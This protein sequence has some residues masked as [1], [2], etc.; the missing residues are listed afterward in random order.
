MATGSQIATPKQTGGGG[1]KY[2]DKVGAY[3]LLCM[4]LQR[5]PFSFDLGLIKRI[6]MQQAAAGWA[7]DDYVITM[8]YGE[9]ENKV[10]VSVKS[11]QQFSENVI[12]GSARDLLWEQ[13]LQLNGRVFDLNRDYFCFAQ[14]PLMGTISSDLNTLIHLAQQQDSIDLE[15]NLNTPRYTSKEKLVLYNSFSCP[16]ELNKDGGNLDL[17]PGEILSRL[18][19][20]E[21]D[22]ESVVS[23]SENDMLQ[24]SV[25]VLSDQSDSKNV[26]LYEKLQQICRDRRFK[27][28]FIILPELLNELKA[29][30]KLRTFPSY[31]ADLEK[32][33]LTTRR[34]LSI[35]KT[36]V[37]KDFSID[38]SLLLAEINTKYQ[39]SSTIGILSPS[40][41]GKT[42]LAKLYV[43]SILSENT[44][45]FLNSMYFETDIQCK[46]AMR[47][48][49]RELI[50]ANTK[51][52]F[53]II[54]DGLEKF[55]SDEQLQHLA[56]LLNELESTKGDFKLLFTCIDEDFDEVLL[57]LYGYGVTQFDFAKIV[58]NN[59]GIN[60]L[61]LTA[62][63]P[64]L[65]D[66]LRNTQLKQLLYN[67]KILDALS[68]AVTKGNASELSQ[69]SESEIIDFLWKKIV[70]SGNQGLLCSNV[71]KL[72]AKLQ[73]ENLSMGIS[74]SMIDSA[75]ASALT[76]L[77]DLDV[78]YEY[79]D[80]LYF[81]HD[82]YGDWARYKI[83]RSHS[84][85]G[86]SFLLSI[87]VVSPLWAKAIR[88]YG[89]YLLEVK[90]SDQGWLKL[91]EQFDDEK[92]KEK[93]IRNI[94]IESVIFGINAKN[95]LALL[96]ESLLSN[97]CLLFQRL[98]D[99]FLIKAT[100][101]N[102]TVLKIASTLK[103]ISLTQASIY[104]RIPT[105]G[106][107]LP[108]INFI[109]EHNE[110][111]LKDNFY[112]CA[113]IARDWLLFT[114]KKTA[115]RKKMATLA[116]EL[117]KVVIND[118]SYFYANK[119]WKQR[120]FEAL[121]LG[122]GEV[123]E[124]AAEVI[125]KLAGL[126]E[127][128]AR[129]TSLSPDMPMKSYRFRE[130]KKWPYGP[131]IYPD[132][133]FINVCL[134]NGVLQ[135]VFEVNPELANE[136]M[137]A[138]LIKAPADDYYQYG[139]KD[140]LDLNVPR[141][142][143]PPLYHRGPFLNFLN[144]NPYAALD[145]IIKLVDFATSQ[146]CSQFEHDHQIPFV[147]I[148]IDAISK[149]YFGDVSTFFWYRDIGVPPDSLASA[150]MAVERYLYESREDL[151]KVEACIKLILEKSDSL[152]FI[153]MLVSCGKGDTRLFQRVLRSL[154]DV[155]DFYTW[156]KHNLVSFHLEQ[157][158]LFY[159]PIQQAEEADEWNKTFHRVTSLQDLMVNELLNR[160]EFKSIYKEV[161]AKW[162]GKISKIRNNKNFDIYQDRLLSFFYPSNYILK[163]YKE[164]L[165]YYEY[166]EPEELTKRMAPSRKEYDDRQ[167]V[168]N[169]F[170]LSQILEKDQQISLE[171]AE[172]LW[173]LLEKLKT[174]KVHDWF[175]TLETPLDSIFGGYVL[176]LKFKEVWINEHP[177]YYQVIVAYTEA[178][179]CRIENE[180]IKIFN[181]SVQHSWN[182]FVSDLIAYLLKDGDSLF[183]RKSITLIFSNFHFESVGKLFS[184]IGKLLGWNH[185][186]FIELQ[187]F[188]FAYASITADS[189]SVDEEP[190]ALK[191]ELDNLNNLFISGKIETVIQKWES[192]RGEQKEKKMHKS[193]HEKGDVLELLHPG[194]NL[195]LLKSAYKQLP[196]RDLAVYNVA[197]REHIVFIWEQA[198]EQVVWQF[199]TSEK[200]SGE[201]DEFPGEFDL[202][203]IRSIPNL[204]TEDI[205]ID[206]FNCF[207]EPLLKFG[208]TTPDW[209]EIYCASI[210]HANL[211]HVDRYDRFVPQW[212]RI[213]EFCK[214][215]KNWTHRGKM[216]R[217][218]PLSLFFLETKR[219]EVW[220]YDY[221]AF[222]NLTAPLY[223]EFFTKKW[224][225]PS[226]VKAC[227][228]FVKTISGRSLLKI[229][230]LSVNLAV[231]YFLELSKVPIPEDAVRKPFYAIAEL[232][233]FLGRVWETDESEI[234]RD[235]TMFKSYK[236]LVE[237]LVSLHDPIG[238]ELQE[239]LIE[240]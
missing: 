156:E 124:P 111:T 219:M 36:T 85:E 145:G 199:G 37:G 162:E 221:S 217:Y 127:P 17:L 203:V 42:T 57:R 195:D 18:M 223:K 201:F 197:E 130:A 25:Q 65:L 171:D 123:L 116:T 228:L 54:I 30:F 45:L 47:Y 128:P 96:K 110:I 70:E 88:Q 225:A 63:F 193:Y 229:G 91:Y 83:I 115:G 27:G 24:F 120:A 216:S 215:H 61:E 26:Q 15:R 77:R 129:K 48:S 136:V 114:P 40:G 233:V 141:N 173:E 135:Q 238:I 93:I 224:T 230:L 152:A 87:D 159:L 84:K 164:E 165:S 108:V 101:V 231:K 107:W 78:I 155:M 222:I 167:I 6:D 119:E 35:I 235:D 49:I 146:W 178:T 90:G 226:V 79:E 182:I 180:Q 33:E 58:I 80:Y 143:A 112:Y 68:Y 32:I 13:R 196:M 5:N 126:I 3:F 184:T 69:V 82:L 208:Y 148:E 176:L 21:F 74:N 64:N 51:G 183:L 133:E 19:I 209:I 234:R 60:F 12:Y 44:V 198:F 92:S 205:G 113:R 149:K 39:N 100:T 105:Y 67:I 147:E 207:A 73:A 41:Y 153:G 117:C 160:D 188:T 213:V 181:F 7:L 237:F 186:L 38:R 206:F 10:G 34:N 102:P 23:N 194:M 1:F 139:G 150:L 103:T 4:L 97:N 214:N 142:W 29:W 187:N 157:Y 11:N 202:W 132:D 239:M 134:N 53:F 177:D 154:L 109:F 169:P 104:N 144:I 75:S 163:P 46:L 212:Q 106:Y 81:Q 95:N 189:Y 168:P 76:M 43:E 125:R 158:G 240:K 218:L 204:I 220:D 94:L 121:L 192:F 151:A 72:I 190:S 211:D 55:Y 8:G 140:D 137:L 31:T 166:V 210:F 71:A 227:C 52:H 28:G 22:F 161:T 2:E 56:M 191:I 200:E 232:G 131:F 175:S 20:L 185:E 9:E 118:R 174:R 138:T 98:L 170:T 50:N 236:E 66:I 99:V 62:H 86:K 172:S 89:I 16:T 179:F 59:S 14:P 122:Y